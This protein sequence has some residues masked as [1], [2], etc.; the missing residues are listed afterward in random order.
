MPSS[1]MSI[2]PEARARLKR[3]SQVL[4]SKPSGSCAPAD[5]TS[6]TS[7]SFSGS[8][9]IILGS[10]LC[11]YEL[12]ERGTAVEPN[13]LAA[14]DDLLQAPPP[15]IQRLAL[16]GVIAVAIVHGGDAAFGVI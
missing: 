2:S 9:C 6:Q 16:L 5:V 10:P 1:G 3:S 15:D 8:K 11:R 14:M 12:L 4:R 7:S 13:H